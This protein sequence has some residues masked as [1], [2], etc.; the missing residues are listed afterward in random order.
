MVGVGRG[1]CESSLARCSLVALDT[2]TPNNGNEMTVL[3]D[4]YVQQKQKVTDYRTQWSGI[5]SQHLKGSD[6]VTLEECRINV[7]NIL[8]GN[9]SLS[10]SSL[11]EERRRSVVVLIGHALHNDLN[12]LKIKHPRYLTRDTA[13]Y[14]PLM[15]PG[16]RKH[17]PRKLSSLVEEY[18][19]ISIQNNSCTNIKVKGGLN[20]CT[21][22]CSDVLD[23][24]GGLIRVGHDSVEDAAATLLLYR[25]VSNDWEASLGKP[26]T[27]LSPQGNNYTK[28]RKSTAQIT[29]YLDACN[30]PFGLR[31]RKTSNFEWDNTKAKYQLMCKRDQENGTRSD[32]IP[33]L[34]HMI[35]LSSSGRSQD[36]QMPPVG[37]IVIVFDGASFN[38]KNFRPE[39]CEDLGSNLF[40][41]VTDDGVEADDVL[42][43]RCAKDLNRMRRHDT[44]SRKVDIDHVVST[45]LHGMG[46][47]DSLVDCKNANYIVAKRKGRSKKH[48]KLFEKLRLKR[49]E[50]GA[51]CLTPSFI[52]GS[53]RLHKYNLQLSR[54]LQR[55]K[56]NQIMEYELKNCSS[57]RSVV[58]TDDVLLSNRIVDM[59]GVVL[60]YKQFL[61]MF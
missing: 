18:C 58:V 15:Q 55:A 20:K 25:K 54:E 53:E 52:N 41:E 51:C 33:L 59:G 43:E 17:Y 28:T 26:L 50:E 23:G 12:V 32:M 42:V 31:Q 27:L 48:K 24:D 36:S 61:Q 10:S 8:T 13:T 57:V 16:R 49:P 44:T 5:T 34:H 3:Y 30:L 9:S 38:D 37:K 11:E 45:L 21:G 4:V 46:E 40:L 22:T 2:S 19:G 29:L 60:G 7:S 39:S 35:S 14:A 6:V 56:V 1:G 47:S